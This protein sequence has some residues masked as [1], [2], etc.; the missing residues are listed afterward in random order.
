MNQLIAMDIHWN[1]QSLL[2]FWDYKSLTAIGINC[3]SNLTATGTP[4]EKRHASE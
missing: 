3:L 4:T 1:L 2:G